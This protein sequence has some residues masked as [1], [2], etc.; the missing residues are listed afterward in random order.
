MSTAMVCSGD[1]YHGC[2]YHFQRS[3]ISVGTTMHGCLWGVLFSE[4]HQMKGPGKLKFSKF[5]GSF[6]YTASSLRHC[7]FRRMNI[8]RSFVECL[9]DQYV[10]RLVVQLAVL[11]FG[12]LWGLGSFFIWRL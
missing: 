3:T 11:C 12:T 10:R 8:A 2:S 5:G 7:S 1:M 4:I 6:V 9:L